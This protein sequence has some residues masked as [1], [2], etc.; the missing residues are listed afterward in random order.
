[1]KALTIIMGVLLTLGGIFLTVT[2][3]STY[4]SL[5][6]VV[7]LILIIS[8]INLL[9]NYKRFKDTG[10]V[11]GWDVFFGIVTIVMGAL[12]LFNSYASFFTEVML[13]ALFASWLL[14]GGIVRIVM[15]F[16]IKKLG[17]SLW[18]LVLALGIL[19]VVVGIYGFINPF[20]MA[21]ALGLMVGIMVIIQGV[22][23]IVAGASLTTE[24]PL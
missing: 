23:L 7:G 13:V 14:I 16:K 19:S 2:P 5:W 8:G 11:S 17:A 22:N 3:L 9:V 10:L 15:S 1:M 24:E 12:V 6:V 4:L 18:G 20:A 21:F